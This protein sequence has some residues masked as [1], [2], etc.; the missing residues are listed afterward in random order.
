[1]CRKEIINANIRNVFYKT[2]EGYKKIEVDS[3]IHPADH[4]KI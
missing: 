2:K 3:W 1:M 4:I